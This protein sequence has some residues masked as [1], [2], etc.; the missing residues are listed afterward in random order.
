M[1]EHSVI[2]APRLWWTT[3][4]ASPSKVQQLPAPSREWPEQAR[5]YYRLG[6]RAALDRVLQMASPCF[7]LRRR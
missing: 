5:L 1:S 2:A 4:H 7:P 6:D 3:E